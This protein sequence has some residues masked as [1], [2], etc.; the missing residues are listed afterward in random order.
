[1][2]NITELIYYLKLISHLKLIIHL[3]IQL[4][5]LSELRVIYVYVDWFTIS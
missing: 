4:K 3:S 2:Q 1:M 5:K